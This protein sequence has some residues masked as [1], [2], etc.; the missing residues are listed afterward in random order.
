VNAAAGRELLR[1]FEAGAPGRL[2]VTGTASVHARA[3]S[4]R[5][6]QKAGYTKS[7]KDTKDTKIF[8]S[9]VS[10]ASFV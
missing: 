8:M 2:A 6:A 1:L 9:L 3:F 7:T 5:R 10:L 4:A